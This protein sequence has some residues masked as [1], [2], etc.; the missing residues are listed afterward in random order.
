MFS[1]L[2]L[3]HH[4]PLP[5]RP[6]L[7]TAARRTIAASFPRRAEVA[8]EDPTPAVKA[9][10]PVTAENTEEPTV[11]EEDVPTETSADRPG[12]PTSYREFM[13]SPQYGAQYEFAKPQNW[14]RPPPRGGRD[15]QTPI[16]NVR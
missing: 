8:S 6:C 15:S 11:T 14:L 13:E 5:L 7:H 2:R 12:I 10:E 1:L 4:H 9:D 3:A 16:A